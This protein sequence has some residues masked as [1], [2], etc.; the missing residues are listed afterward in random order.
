MD[1]EFIRP[2]NE[3]VR[4][5]LAAPGSRLGPGSMLCQW[6]VFRTRHGGPPKVRALRCQAG[7]RTGK[8]SSPPWAGWLP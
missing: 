4:P 7:N 3:V 1:S 5:H 8:V 6:E 2:V